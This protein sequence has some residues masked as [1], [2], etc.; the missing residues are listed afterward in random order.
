MEALFERALRVD[1]GTEV[2]GDVNRYLCVRVCGF[3]EQFLIATGRAACERTSGGVGRSFALSWLDRSFNPS[4]ANIET[5]LRRFSPGWADDLRVFLSDE[6]RSSRLNALVGI[7]NDI[8]HGKNQGVSP[9]QVWDYFAL[10]L[11]VSEWI[12]D[13][14]D[15]I[16][17]QHPASLP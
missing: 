3:T 2:A 7:R 16:P 12:A 10:V 13:R 5:F 14:L 9:T 15:P 11:E 8:A 17:G 6:E 1:A 4:A